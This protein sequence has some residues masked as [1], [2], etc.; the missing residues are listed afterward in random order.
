MNKAYIS[1]S[2]DDG[3]IDNYTIVYPILKKYQLPAT[4][5]ITTGYVEGKFKKGSL[6]DADPMDL[7]MVKKLYQDSSMEIA[8]HG[9]WHKNTF[10][11][12]IEGKQELERHLDIHQKDVISGFASPGTGLS[13]DYYHE[14]KKALTAEGILYIR[15]SLRYLSY[16]HLKTY[17]R[18][19]SRVLPF[20]F[21]YKWAYWDTLMGPLQNDLIY[22]VPVLSSVSTA[23]LKSLISGAI[24]RKKVCVLMFHSIVDDGEIRDNWD[25]ERSKFEKLCRYLADA[26]HQGQLEVVT[27]KKAYQ[28]LKE[29]NN[30]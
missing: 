28:L 12:I 9:Y 24:K 27:S 7:D 15:L 19:A 20:P 1:F 25:Y 3:R 16:S 4:F 17:I 21:L 13:M 11:D 22:S 6:T 26:Q 18:K 10:E 23:Q 5:N 30:V 8:G 2:F 29:E 14:H